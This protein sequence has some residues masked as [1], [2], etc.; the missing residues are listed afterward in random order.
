MTVENLQKALVTREMD[1]KQEL[2]KERS[3]VETMKRQMRDYIKKHA[4]S[5]MDKEMAVVKLEKDVDVLK[6]VKDG[7]ALV[8][9][10][11]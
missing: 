4:Q 2:E 10:Y 11:S 5:S 7:A 8:N 9:W 6:K 3:N 1:V